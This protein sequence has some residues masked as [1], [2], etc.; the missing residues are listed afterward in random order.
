M[1]IDKIRFLLS[2]L[3]VTVI[4][5]LGLS[6]QDFRSQADSAYDKGNYQEA[7]R[8]YQATIDS[9]GSTSDLYYNLGNA[10][11]R[12]G[13]LAKAILGYERALRLDPANE[14]ARANLKFVN[15][16]IVDKK[17]QTGSFIS[18]AFDD[19][20]SLMSSNSWAI[21][22][23]C[24]FVLTIAAVAAYYFLPSVMVKKIGFF[25]GIIALLLTVIF[26][27]LSFH[28]KSMQQS[29]EFAIITSPT[30]ILSTVPREPSN[31]QEEAM[32]L[33]EGTKVQILSSVS[34]EADST[35]QTWHEVQIDNA[36]R[37][38]INDA[39]VENILSK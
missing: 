27:I 12:N 16:R 5:C 30:T 17:G 20:T 11:Y 29:E 22:A 21:L 3:V 26:I 4:G 24:F 6:A 13:K 38:W 32:L 34:F 31:R 9:L 19:I 8:L 23:L 1:N 25:G 18:N 7:A 15:D 28:G 33:H 39:D 37:A 35:R 2:F 14:D 36:H 10:Q